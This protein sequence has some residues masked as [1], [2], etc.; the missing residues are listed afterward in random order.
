MLV[1]ARPAAL[2]LGEGRRLVREN[3]A[4]RPGPRLLSRG[5]HVIPFLEHRAQGN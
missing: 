5:S 3:V 4:D 2:L 1:L